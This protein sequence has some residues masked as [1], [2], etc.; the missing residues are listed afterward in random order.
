MEYVLY[1]MA[2]FGFIAFCSMGSLASRISK[3]EKQLGSIQ[4]SPAHEEKLSLMKVMRDYIG[5]KVE[6][7]FRGEDCDMDLVNAT[8]RKGAC[9]VEDVDKDWVRVHITY[10]KT[11]KV[12][13]IRLQEISGVKGISE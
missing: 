10:D 6:L 11:D 8:M 13:L 9:I 5:K 2:I 3:L 1:A 4:G 12:K 7:E